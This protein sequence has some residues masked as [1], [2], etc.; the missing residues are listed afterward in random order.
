MMKSLLELYGAPTHSDLVRWIRDQY[1]LGQNQSHQNLH[2]MRREEI[3]C[4]V[5]LYRDDSQADFERIIR[6]VFEDEIVQ[7]Q[8]MRLIAVAREQNVTR[9][10]VDEVASLYDKPAVRTLASAT[11]NK[12]FHEEERRLKLHEVM[13]ETHRL[14]QL[15]NEVL[16]WQYTGAD[17]K[18]RLRVVTPDLFDALPDPRDQRVMAGVLIDVCP[19]SIAPNRERLPHYELWDAQYRYLLN[20]AGELVDETGMPAAAPLEH[21]QDRIPGVLLHKREP[22]D[23]LLDSRPGRDITSAHLGVGLLNVMIMR[24]S[25]SQGER[26]PILKGNLAN[27]AKNQRMDGETPIALP[28]EVEALMLDSKTDPDHYISVKKEKLTSVAQT[29]GIGYEQLTYQESSDAASGKSY[30]LRREKL[31]ELRG[32]QRRRAYTNEYEVIDLMGFDPEGAKVDHQE[33]AM[34]QDAV[35]EVDLL[36][37]KMRLGL[38]SPITYLMR[39][40]PDLDRGGAEAL[41]R[42]NLSDWQ[43]LVAVQRSMNM[44][45]DPTKP[46]EDPKVNG[47]K[48]GPKQD[49]KPGDE[50]QDP[51]PADDGADE[52]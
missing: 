18:T 10:I 46:G 24:L 9:R 49:E 3:A 17:E 40:D 45:N 4:R 12:R 38:D 8:R 14:L 29:Y 33:Q 11:E 31:S 35:E 21:G 7:L 15:C 2:R 26:Q 1:G 39:K 47:A 43:K 19:M 48:G 13:Q 36:E 34:P 23:R 6:L 27:V 41:L 51:P 22:T 30:Q 42:E 16:V 37:K 44:P 50:Q 25:K 5:R 28:P 52:N 32:E 20:A